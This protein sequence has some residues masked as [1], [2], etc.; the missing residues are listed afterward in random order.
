VV[1]EP[2]NYR[3]IGH[4]CSDR[5]PEQARTS[6]PDVSKYDLNET[7]GAL[8]EQFREAALSFAKNGKGITALVTLYLG[9]RFA[10][11][12]RMQNA[13]NDAVREYG[14]YDRVEELNE[15]MDDLLR[16]LKRAGVPYHPAMGK[17]RRL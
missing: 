15:A 9:D 17:P 16:E 8:A 3:E 13:R 5:K 4:E 7:Q 11:L 10:E 2:T 1:P 12:F 14:N 6:P